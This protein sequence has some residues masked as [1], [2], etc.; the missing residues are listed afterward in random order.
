MVMVT[1]CGDGAAVAI[2]HVVAVGDDGAL[3][4][5]QITEKPPGST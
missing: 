3:S 5:V 2:N 1:V 4:Q